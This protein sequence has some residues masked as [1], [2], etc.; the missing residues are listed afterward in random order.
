MKSHI[1]SPA[2]IALMG[3]VACQFP[4]NIHKGN[5]RA[6]Q[7]VGRYYMLKSTEEGKRVTAWQPWVNAVKAAI[8]EP[9]YVFNAP[10]D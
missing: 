1:I 6:E 5:D 7:L 4:V 3:L 2:C 9:N 8:N 10:M